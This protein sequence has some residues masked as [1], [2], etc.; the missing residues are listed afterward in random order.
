MKQTLSC[1]LVRFAVREFWLVAFLIPAFAVVAASPSPSI[2]RTG[3]MM[4]AFARAE[5]GPLDDSQVTALVDYLSRTVS[6]EPKPQNPF[7]AKAYAET[8][9]A[10]PLPAP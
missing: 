1:R 7:D 2:G 10:F 5:G 9:S 4:P 3:S 6:A 8:M